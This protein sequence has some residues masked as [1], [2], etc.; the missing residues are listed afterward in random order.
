MPAPIEVLA[1]TVK[2]VDVPFEISEVGNIIANQTVAVKSRIDSQIIS[3]NFKDGDK[4]EAGQVLIKLDDLALKSQLAQLEANVARDQAQL[5]NY[6]KQ[7]ERTLKVFQTGFETKQNLDNAQGLYEAQVA[8]VDADKAAV[9]NM[10]AQFNYTIITAPIA[11]RTG[12]IS[13]TL[14]N[15][16]KANDVTPLVT[17]NQLDPIKAK[18]SISQK[19]FDQ[20]QKAMKEGKVEVKVSKPESQETIVGSLEYIEN[21][22]DQNNNFAAYAVFANK[23]EK[24]WPGMYVNLITVLGTEKNAITTPVTAIQNGPDN[25][26][27]VY[28]I[29]AGKAKKRTVKVSRV[30]NDIAVISSG[31][32]S[33]EEVITDGILSLR[34][35]SDVKVGVKR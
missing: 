32:H 7:Y 31:V 29:E 21:S 5:D 18:F 23:E 15:E 19:Y 35:G 26:Q 13:L 8:T 28:V 16:V 4:V 9:E 6:K 14:G 24:L 10:A 17:I 20:V 34:E 11:G 12:T 1:A 33:G 27:F 30:V 2:T 25:S 3:I 22:I